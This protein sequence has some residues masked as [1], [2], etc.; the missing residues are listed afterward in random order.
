MVNN[1][2]P[3]NSNSARDVENQN[4]GNISNQAYRTVE[5]S[6]SNKPKDLVLFDGKNYI[7]KSGWKPPSR[8]DSYIN[9]T[10][11]QGNVRGID[12]NG[13]PVKVTKSHYIYKTPWLYSQDFYFEGRGLDFLKGNLESGYFL[14]WRANGKVFMYTISGRKI[15][16]P[17]ASNSD[18]HEDPFVYDIQDNDGDGVF[19]TLFGGSAYDDL[20]VPNWVLK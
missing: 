18:H 6:P 3:I 15:V 7:K 11:D 12:K 5:S 20:I 4:A 17:T 14:E 13:K 8:R 1:A 9:D 2:T 19:E 16:P 10:Y